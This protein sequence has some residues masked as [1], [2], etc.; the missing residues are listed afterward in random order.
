MAGKSGRTCRKIAFI[1]TPVEFGGSER[2]SLSFLKQYRRQD[3]EICPII[4]CRPWETEN[5]FINALE[6]EGISYKL[7]P[8]ISKPPEQ[9]KDRFRLLRCGFL[10]YRELRK[11]SFDL[12]HTN[13]Y[14]AD[15]LGVF[16]AR[17]LRIPVVTTCH[18]FISN[19]R[20][21]RLYNFLDIISFRFMSRVITVSEKL[22]EEL[23]DKGIDRN[24][25]IFIQNSVELRRDDGQHEQRRKSVREKH[26]IGGKQWVLGY[27][28]RLSM[29]KGIKFLLE[30]GTALVEKQSGLRI[31]VIGEGPQRQEI[32]RY[33]EQT[34]MADKVVFVGFQKN[35]ED[36]L[37]AF[38]I[39]ILPS[40]TEGTSMA[41]LEAMATG[42]PIVATAVGGTPKVITSGENGLLVPAANPQAITDAVNNII[43][44]EQ[45]RRNI[46]AGALKTIEERFSIDSWLSKIDTIY[47]DVLS[48]KAHAK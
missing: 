16:A 47:N 28:G 33:V 38:D 2:V 26:G 35:V 18:G 24:K 3:W 39:F 7:I 13:G 11:G 42:L 46:S 17:F 43:E 12:V 40:L 20:T 44:D 31:L 15:I 30:A 5:V 36:F 34:N 1:L 25:L 21:Y 10:L 45:L 48:E 14:S 6:E 19:T 8:I 29:E 27:V 22:R 9:G 32:E 4:L 41:L 23:S 37:T